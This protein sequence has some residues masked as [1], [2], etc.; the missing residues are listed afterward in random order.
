M[1][2]LDRLFSKDRN[3]L[4]KLRFAF[5]NSINAHE[6]GDWQACAFRSGFV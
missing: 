1:K 4:P 6:T 3:E 5:V 2:V